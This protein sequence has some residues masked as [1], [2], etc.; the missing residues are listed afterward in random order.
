[1]QT[2]ALKNSICYSLLRPPFQRREAEINNQDKHKQDDATCDQSL[3]VQIRRI[4]HSP[5]QYLP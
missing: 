3:T 2:Y 1:M 5:G 4:A